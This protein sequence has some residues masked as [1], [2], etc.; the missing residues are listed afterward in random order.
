[1]R[2]I[3]FLLACLVTLSKPT[4]ALP[5]S[6]Q[7]LQQLMQVNAEWQKQTDIQNIVLQNTPNN[8]NGWIAAHLSLVEQTLRQRNTQYLSASQRKNRAQLLDA[9]SA[10]AKAGIFPINDY[11]PYQNPIFIDR[12]G[13]HC[14]V[15][16][17]MMKSGHESLAREIDAHEKFAYVDEIKTDGVEEWAGEHGFTIDELAWIQP[18]YPPTTPCY[19]LD[20]GL[21]GTVNVIITDTI[22]QVMY[23]GGSFS[24]S[25]SGAVCTNIAAWISGFAGWDWV[26]VGSGVNGPV[27]DLLLHNNKLYV[28][29]EFTLAGSIAARNIAVY[30]IALGQWQA[31]GN[32]DSTVRALAVYN[33]ELYAGGNFTGFVSKWN[34]TTW[35]D[36]AQGFL[37]GEGVRTL[38]VWNNELVIGGNFELATGA[39]RRH[40]ATYNGTYI[41][42][43]GFG[44]VTP[45][46]DFEIHNGKLYAACDAVYGSDTCALALFD[47]VNGQGWETVISTQVSMIDGFYGNAVYKLMSAGGKLYCAGDFQCSSGLTWGSHL[48]TFERLLSGG[49]Y[50]NAYTPLITPDAPVRALALENSAIYFGGDF[51]TNAFTDTLNHIA[52][53]QVLPSIIR[54]TENN[55]V[56]FEVYPNPASDRL[57]VVAP[58]QQLLT[59]LEMVDASGRILCV[60]EPHSSSASLDVSSLASGL[61]LLRLTINMHTSVIRFFKN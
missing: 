42:M 49:N 21:N 6:D 40:V 51:I 12:R 13:T 50:Y 24:Q 47:E 19:D 41:G 7:M 5:T 2:V 33:N 1:M 18:G 17:L 60:S 9:L 15:G 39:L 44:T 38:E 48:M 29:G 59:R 28:G 4:L 31:V 10:Y 22:S 26:P 14:A 45:V 61:Y 30:D 53:L 8:F 52:Y 55:Q 16:Y 34:G 20:G 32:L 57:L 58:S 46:N 43:L 23:V 54:E 25:T 3:F 35:T 27:Y 37:Y 11:L 36:V 56:G